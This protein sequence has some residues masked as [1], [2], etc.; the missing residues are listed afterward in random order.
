MIQYIAQ[1]IVYTLA[2]TGLLIIGYVV[3][4]K[5]SSVN[6]LKRNSLI[7]IEDILRLP[8]RKVLYVINCK[9]EEFLIASSNDRISLISKL[10]EAGQDKK[11]LNKD[12]IEKYL[13]EKNEQNY[14]QEEKINIPKKEEEQINK[15]YF[16]KS[17]LKELSD[18]NQTKRG[19]Y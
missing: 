7:K 4:K 10:G 15:K 8:D 13:S 19:N 2:M 1:F 6:I 5:T 14:L 18:K 17:L 9:D 12:M 16:I 3:Y 11:K